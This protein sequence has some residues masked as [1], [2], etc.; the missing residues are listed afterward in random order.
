MALLAALAP[1]PAMVP[2]VARMTTLASFCWV[3]AS[4]AEAVVGRISSSA[5]ALGAKDFSAAFMI[6]VLSLPNEMVAV[7]RNNVRRFRTTPVRPGVQARPC[8]VKGVRSAHGFS[9]SQLELPRSRCG[10]FAMQGRACKGLIHSET[11]TRIGKD[12]RFFGKIPDNLRQ[13]RLD[14]ASETD[15]TKPGLVSIVTQRKRLRSDKKHKIRSHLP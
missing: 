1:A 7:W 4:F 10:R 2:P 9:A 5:R 15:L 13:Q 8:V 12:V 11:R 14:P 3:S 6:I